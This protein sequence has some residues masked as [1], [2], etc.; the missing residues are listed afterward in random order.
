MALVNDH[1]LKWKANNI[2]YSTYG[3]TTKPS[4]PCLSVKTGG[5]GPDIL[6]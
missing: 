1:P 2:V 4:T 6:D 3:Y 5:G